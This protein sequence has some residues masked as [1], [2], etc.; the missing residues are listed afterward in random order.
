MKKIVYP[1]FMAAITAGKRPVI[2]LTDPSSQSS[3]K[4]RVSARVAS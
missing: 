4:K 3:P 2:L 1:L